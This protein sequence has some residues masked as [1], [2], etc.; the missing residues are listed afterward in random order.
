MP[1][2]RCWS[3]V[4]DKIENPFKK[5]I[6]EKELPE[7]LKEKVINDINLIKLSLELSE[8][9]FVSIP[10]IMFNFLDTEKEEDENIETKKPKNK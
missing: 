1:R 9:F 3:Y 8:L 2:K 10:E 7:S 6:E 4:K 5:M